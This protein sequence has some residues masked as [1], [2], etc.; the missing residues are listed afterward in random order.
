MP[1]RGALQG[2]AFSAEEILSLSSV[3]EE[4]LTALRLVDRNDPVVSLVVAR[5]VELAKP[6]EIEAGALRDAVLRSFADD[7]RQ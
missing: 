7:H 5:I 6:G 1:I 3:F 2:Q 4:C